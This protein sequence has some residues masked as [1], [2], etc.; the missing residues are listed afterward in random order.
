MLTFAP[1]ARAVTSWTFLLVVFF[2]H[3]S[4]EQGFMFKV[5]RGSPQLQVL[6]GTPVML[7]NSF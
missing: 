1:N 2:L 7:N 4:Y 6:K 5:D 3:F